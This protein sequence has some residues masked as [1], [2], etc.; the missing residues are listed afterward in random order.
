MNRALL[1]PPEFVP[2]SLAFGS[3]IHGAIGFFLRQ[4]KKGQLPALADLQ[5]YFEGLWQLETSTRPIRYTEK[6]SKEGLLDLATRMLAVFHAGLEPRA[7]VV[8]VEFPF[9]VPLVSQETGEVLEPSLVGSLSP[10]ST[11]TGPAAT[12]PPTSAS[13]ASSRRSSTP[14]PPTPSTPSS[15]GTARAA[16]TSRAAGRGGEASR[17]SLVLVLTSVS[18]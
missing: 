13:S 14:S 6:E 18:D 11:A 3:G 16:P 7:E 1:L 15:A 2:A 4:V 5:G 9:E 17:V 10:S 12:A 8:D